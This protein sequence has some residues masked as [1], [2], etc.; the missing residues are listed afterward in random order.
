MILL[1]KQNPS[2]KLNRKIIPVI[3]GIILIGSILSYYVSTTSITPADKL[4][5]PQDIYLV[6]RHDPEKGFIFAIKET[7]DKVLYTYHQISEISVKKDQLVS[8]HLVNGD[9]DEKH[10]FNINEF[11]I[12]TKDLWYFEGDTSTFV[13][14][15]IGTFRYYCSLHPE[16]SGNFT[17]K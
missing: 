1:S 2:K 3:I 4:T 17:V 14:N 5:T 9:K 7:D 10:D 8:I 6:A 11:N 16:M 15:K 12:H 13:A